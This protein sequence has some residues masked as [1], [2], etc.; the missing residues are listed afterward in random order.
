[1]IKQL[2]LV[3]AISKELS[4]QQPGI[5]ISQAQLAAIIAAANDICAAFEPPET[6]ARN[7]CNSCND[8]QRGGCHSGCVAYDK[9]D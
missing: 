4:N 2:S 5:T 1:M 9:R 8:W 3:A 6:P 7:L